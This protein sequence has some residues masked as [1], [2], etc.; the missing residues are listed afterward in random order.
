[1]QTNPEKKPKGA[2]D[3]EYEK[4]TGVQPEDKEEFALILFN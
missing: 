4:K 1:M 3:K 2:K